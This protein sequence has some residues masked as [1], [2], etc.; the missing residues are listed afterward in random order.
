ML[1]KITLALF[2]ASVIGIGLAGSLM[3]GPSATPYAMQAAG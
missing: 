3:S 1:R 2:I